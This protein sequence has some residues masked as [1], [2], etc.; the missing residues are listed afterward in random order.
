MI[1]RKPFL[2]IGVDARVLLSPITGIG[3]YTLEVCKALCKIKN[4]QLYLYS[5]SPNSLEI[6]KLLI[7]AVIHNSSSRSKIYTQ[8]WSEF[9]LPLWLKRDNVDVFWG[10]AH[11]LP[12]FLP[13][14]ILSVV[15]IHDLVWKYAG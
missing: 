5:P 1:T 11:R 9:V 7:P 12:H 3:R 4:V 10:P 15:T 14:R 8:L 6:T 13:R 2:K